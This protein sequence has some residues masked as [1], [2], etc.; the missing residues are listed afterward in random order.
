MGRGSDDHLSCVSICE[1][2]CQPTGILEEGVPHAVPITPP[3]QTENVSWKRR[4][5]GVEMKG[6]GERSPKHASFLKS[7]RAYV[8]YPVRQ[9]HVKSVCTSAV[10]T[11]CLHVCTDARTCARCTL[12]VT[13]WRALARLLQAATTPGMHIPHPWRVKNN[14]GK[15][16]CTSLK[17]TPNTGRHHHGYPEN[18]GHGILGMKM[19][20][21]QQL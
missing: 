13:Q 15:M 16:V 21:D 5:Q 11:Q 2:E 6:G 4:K 12:S 14:R 1:W 20:P 18:A 19:C 3:T 8:V 17:T 7:A 9:M 10:C